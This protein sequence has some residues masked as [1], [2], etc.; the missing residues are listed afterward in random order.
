MLEAPEM[1]AGAREPGLHLVRDA[2]TAVVANDCVCL[3]EVV[4][5]TV[6]DAA[7]SLD[8]LGD[9]S[10]DPPRRGA[11]DQIAN[12]LCRLGGDRFRRAAERAPIRVRA[13]GVMHRGALLG[14]K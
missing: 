12:V 1:L 7:D 9:E 6:G 2:E 11:P 14:G 5:G 13:G 8:R 4:G 10:S 3:S